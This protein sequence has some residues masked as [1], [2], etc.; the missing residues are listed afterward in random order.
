M[1]LK[2]ISYPASLGIGL[3]LW[4]F[5]VGSS[6]GS[7][8]PPS[9]NQK[10][11]TFCNNHR[12]KKVGDGDCWDFARTAVVHAGATGGHGHHP[13]KGD[14]VWG[15]LIYYQEQTKSGKKSSGKTESILP[16]DIIQFRDTRFKRKNGKRSGY[17]H[18]TAVVIA[19]ENKGEDL[20]VLHQ[21]AAGKF[22]SETS[23]PTQ[24]LERGWIRIYRPQPAPKK[25]K[26]GKFGTFVD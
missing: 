24:G 22:V 25:E 20:K 4:V 12:G 1:R 9:I 14:Y 17:H 15:K 5:F 19:T 23:L 6:A 2:R 10:I 26:L 16:G 13:N 11:V 7:A 8:E 3:S 18:H 21:N